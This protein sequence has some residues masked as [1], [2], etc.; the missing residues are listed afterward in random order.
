MLGK[1]L[2]GRYFAGSLEVGINWNGNTHDITRRWYFVDHHRGQTDQKAKQ[3]TQ[4]LATEERTALLY[5]R[6]IDT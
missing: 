1:E 5:V 3:M 6:G 2:Q 4:A